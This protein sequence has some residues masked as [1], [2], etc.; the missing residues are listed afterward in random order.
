MTQT[1]L[2][3]FSLVIGGAGSGKSAHAE[4][5]LIQTGRPLLYIA[6]G[7]AYDEEMQRKIKLHQDR[8]GAVWRT[9]E[10]PLDVPTALAQAL[11]QE[12]VLLDCATLW[13]TNHL[14]AESNLETE[15]ARL[16]DAIITCPAPVVVVTNEVG[17]GIV[18]ENALARRFRNA[19]GALNQRLAADADNVTAVMAGLPLVLK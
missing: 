5:L 18:P 4:R 19:Q 12:A 6:T 7:Q 2:P 11:P 10:A 3:Q 14:F 17:A 15:E 1:S 8:R 16:I 9:I 13:L